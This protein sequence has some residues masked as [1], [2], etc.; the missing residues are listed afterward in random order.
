MMY[1]YRVAQ[2]MLRQELQEELSKRGW[3]QKDL[4][5]ATDIE[6]STISNIFNAKQSIML[7]Q[8]HAINQAFGLPTHSFYKDF[9]GECCNES[10]RLKPD[11]T[12]DFILHCIA[13]EQYD[14]IK[15]IVQILNEE[16]N[17]A[18]MIENTFKIA[19]HIFQ[20]S[21]R[22]YSLPFY[23]IVIRNGYNRSEKLAVSYFRRFLILRDLDTTGAG[24]EALYQL[25]EYLP[26]LPDDLKFDAYY[27]ILTFYSALEN[28]PKLL[29]YSNE[30]KEMAIAE[31]QDKY[32]AEGWLYESSAYIGMNNF[33]DA[34]IATKQYAFYGEHYSWLSK[35]NE[36]YISI[37]MS[38]TE[39]IEELM[40]MLQADQLLFVLPVALDAFLKNGM[41]DEAGLY[42]EKY[43][44]PTAALLEKKGPFYLKHKLR[45]TLA[46]T[47]YYFET[48]Q[49]ELG[50][51][52][53]AISLELALTLKN[54]QHVG[55][56]VFTFHDYGLFASLEQKSRFM[57]ILSKGVKSDEESNACYVNN[58][59]LIWFYRNV[60][61]NGIK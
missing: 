42:L 9:I 59:F 20:S 5:E 61:S 23:D 35:C 14:I 51:E 28:W 16:T 8:L 6:N 2:T 48:G 1:D 36:L 24:Y 11:K 38:N 19:E 17:R 21:T 12:S 49:H 15:K 10:G 32:V 60:F 29:S 58:S 30:L 22:N 33:E 45:F 52:Y 31:G 7:P 39:P 18:K 25:M 44:V 4:A 3:K 57:N 50:F 47:Q 54:M 43:Q 26:L 13:I 53:N 34:L 27:R 55:K 46:L 40:S 41:L 37:E 56:A